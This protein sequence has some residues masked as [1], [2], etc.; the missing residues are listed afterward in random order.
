LLSQS[1]RR[2]EELD[3][4]RL[5]LV[6]SACF[7]PLGLPPSLVE[8]ADDAGDLFRASVDE[9]GDLLEAEEVQRSVQVEPRPISELDDQLFEL[10]PLLSLGLLELACVLHVV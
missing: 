9:L 10:L 3:V 5:E 6:A 2:S 7:L 1:L 8:V 4:L